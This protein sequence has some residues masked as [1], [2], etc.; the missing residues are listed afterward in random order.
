MYLLRVFIYHELW[1]T[2]MSH[3]PFFVEYIHTRDRFSF[4]M[5]YIRRCIDAWCCRSLS[6]KEPLILGLF[7]GKWPVKIRHPMTLRHPVRMYMNVPWWCLKLQVIFCKRATMWLKRVYMSVP[8]L[9]RMYMNV[10]WR[11][12]VAK[13]HRMPYFICHFPQK[14]PTSIGSFAENDSQLEEF[15]GSSPPCNVFQTCRR[16]NDVLFIVIFLFCFMYLHCQNDVLFIVV[17]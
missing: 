1:R 5:T 3:V 17:F 6:A 13:T 8:W 2:W 11:Y 10:P 16:Q 12:R 4:S 9:I 7:F 14:S 15:Y